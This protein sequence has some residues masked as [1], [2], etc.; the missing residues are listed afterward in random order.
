MLEALAPHPQGR[1]IDVILSGVKDE[2][3]TRELLFQLLLRMQAEGFLVTGD[4]DNDNTAWT[5]L[6][7]LLRN[8]WLR[9]KPQA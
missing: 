2:G 9:F 1:N 8:W 3:L 6:N 7:P 4:W 5:F